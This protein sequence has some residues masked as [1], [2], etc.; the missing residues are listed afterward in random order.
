MKIEKQSSTI[1]VREDCVIKTFVDKKIS[2][3]WFKTYTCFTVDKPIYTKVIEYTDHT[4]V[5]EKLDIWMPVNKYLKSKK[6][7][8]DRQLC[9]NILSTYFQVITDCVEYSK[10]L[11]KDYWTHDDLTI[12]NFVITNDNKIKLIDPD[13]F[14]FCKNP[15]DYKYSF[16]I[17]ELENLMR[18]L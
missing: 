10:N 12:D 6:I 1:E 17:I 16:G 9:L 3:E 5:M 11:S 14:H 2:D 7:T 18:K 4:L 13:S 15:I 8:L